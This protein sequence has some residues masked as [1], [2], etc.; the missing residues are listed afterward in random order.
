[1]MWT[2]LDE[3][4]V[5][6][7]KFYKDPFFICNYVVQ[8]TSRKPASCSEIIFLILTLRKQELDWREKRGY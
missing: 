2:V 8:V 6:I 3:K 4:M 5:V 7:C 1:M